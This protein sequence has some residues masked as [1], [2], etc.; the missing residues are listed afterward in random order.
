MFTAWID[1]AVAYFRSAGIEA[2][3]A[4]ELALEMLCLLEGAFLFSRALRTPEP[5]LVAGGAAVARVRA[6]L[7]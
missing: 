7:P 3:R 4:H 1:G 2:G 5:V 6:A